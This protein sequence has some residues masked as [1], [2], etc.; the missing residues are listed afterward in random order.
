[1][2]SL[3]PAWARSRQRLSGK[4]ASSWDVDA[5]TTTITA[6]SRSLSTISCKIRTP[7]AMTQ[8]SN[9]M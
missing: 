4:L 1:M 5:A 2:L 6:A 3:S 8:T 7:Q 9:V